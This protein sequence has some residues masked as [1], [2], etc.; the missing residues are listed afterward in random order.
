MDQ[1]TGQPGLEEGQDQALHQPQVG[2]PVPG[3]HG[4]VPP[5]GGDTRDP[6]LLPR[7]R[8][9]TADGGVAGDRVGQ[10]AADPGVQGHGPL[11]QRPG[12]AGDQI[13]V[14]GDEEDDG[15]QCEQADSRPSEQHHHRQAQQD[16]EGGANPH[17]DRVRDLVIGPHGPA[18]L[19]DR[20]PREG[21]GVP[22]GRIGLDAGEPFIRHLL[23]VEGGQAAPWLVADVPDKGER[24]ADADKDPPP[25]PGGGRSVGAARQG[26]DQASGRP[27]H[28][29]V[30]PDGDQPKCDDP[31]QP[32]G[33]TP[34]VAGDEAHHL[35]IAQG[36]LTRRLVLVFVVFGHVCSR[37]G[38]G[39]RRG[40]AGS[41]KESGG[42]RRRDAEAFGA[43]PLS[44]F[45]SRRG[46]ATDAVILPLLSC[47]WGGR[48]HDP[49]ERL[50]QQVCRL[51]LF[52]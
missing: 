16:K 40:A 1:E 28:G 3:P 35:E 24:H 30:Q 48:G 31:G 52:D 10:G 43:Q 25:P 19:A 26:V 29:H 2:E 44:R 8:A 14:R 41:G 6:G 32:P 15:E 13:H 45:G 18:Q 38:A 12:E 23:H 5:E 7:L 36:A 4:G 49:G 37:V 27:G 33:P 34:P 21:V 39:P 11:V 42:D 47:C 20:R 22:V 17:E 50:G 51:I 46:L 9:E